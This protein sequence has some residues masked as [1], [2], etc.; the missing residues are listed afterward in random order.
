MVAISEVRSDTIEA[1]STGWEPEACPCRFSIKQADS[2][3]AGVIRLYSLTSSR[4]SA[5]A[6]PTTRTSPS[7]SLPPVLAKRGIPR[8]PQVSAKASDRIVGGMMS[9][10][11]L[12]RQIYY[13]V[14]MAFP[15]NFSNTNLPQ[16]LNLLRSKGKFAGKSG[17]I[18][19]N[20]NQ[21]CAHRQTAQAVGRTWSGAW[22]V[23]RSQWPPFARI[24][25]WYAGGKKLRHGRTW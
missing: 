15:V 8:A 21:T 3:V 1:K 19:P 13:R 2:A 4:K 12:K 25:D 5:P 6:G 9:W 18:T 22:P 20:S 23:V 17:R 24:G 7:G 16:S 10:I 14:N 11:H